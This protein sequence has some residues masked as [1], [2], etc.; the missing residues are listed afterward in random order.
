MKMKKLVSAAL[1]MAMVLSLVACGG[2]NGG[3]SSGTTPP[4]SSNQGSSQSN[5]DPAPLRRR[6]GRRYHRLG[7]PRGRLGRRGQGKAP[8]RQVHR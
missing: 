8:H 2:Q 4:P 6:H 3:Q 1:A 5:P 7:L